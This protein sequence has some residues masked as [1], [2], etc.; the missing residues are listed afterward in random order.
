MPTVG[1]IHEK[2]VEQNIEAAEKR[3]PAPKYPC[4]DCGQEFSDPDAL[5]DHIGLAHPQAIPQLL[6][7][8]TVAP[9]ELVIRRPIVEAEVELVNCSSVQVHLDGRTNRA[10]D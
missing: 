5:R 10:R 6:L 4:V 3:R 8:G 9:R 1:W 7:S 2:V